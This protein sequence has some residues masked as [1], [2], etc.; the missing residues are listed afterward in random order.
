MVPSGSRNRYRPGRLRGNDEADLI[1]APA[2]YVAQGEHRAEPVTVGTN[3]GRE[4]KTSVGTNQF[5]ERRPI[6]HPARPF[7]ARETRPL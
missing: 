2:Q 3:M 1:A 5:D 7:V 4:E 6:E